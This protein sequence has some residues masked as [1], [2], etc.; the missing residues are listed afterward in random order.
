V[1]RGRA[2]LR[3]APGRRAYS[4]QMWTTTLRAGLAVTA[5][6]A[7]GMTGCSQAASPVAR[8]A[9]VEQRQCGD[10]TAMLDDLA[11]LRNT[12]VLSVEPTY[13]VDTCWGT[14][15]VSG[16]KLL[17]SPPEGV[18]PDRLAR[19]LRCHG[20]RALLRRADA[21]MV[22]DPYWSPDGWVDIEATPVAGR[23]AILLRAD[24]VQKN[25]RVLRR[26]RAFA[27]LHR[28]GTNAQ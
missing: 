25:I 28:L 11:I 22:D 16:T 14:W 8:A 10:A 19:V 6:A 24:T 12:T 2:I 27:A 4:Y 15:Q 17:M 5:A 1:T 3:N 21:S 13:V 7:L 18:S 20:A 9:S 26:A 23:L